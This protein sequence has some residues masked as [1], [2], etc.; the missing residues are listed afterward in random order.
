MGKYVDIEEL[1]KVTHE[2]LCLDFT[3][4][5][6]DNIIDEMSSDDIVKVIRCKDCKK[7]IEPYCTRFIVAMQTV[8][9]NDFCS[10][11]ERKET[12]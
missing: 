7:Y 1:K 6:L 3:K 2:K 10:Y 9:D 4:I 8:T 11:G 5:I 12:K